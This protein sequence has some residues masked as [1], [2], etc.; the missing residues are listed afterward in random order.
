MRGLFARLRWICPLAILLCGFVGSYK[1]WQKSVENENAERQIIIDTIAE[2]V[3]Q[4]IKKCFRGAILLA[5]GVSAFYD[6]S[7][8]IEDYEFE[9]FTSSFLNNDLISF[10]QWTPKIDFKNK[11]KFEYQT[12]RSLNQP[13]SIYDLD[14]RLNRID[15]KD[16]DV[17]FP[18]SYMQPATGNH[19]LYGYDVFSDPNIH[20]AF[21]SASESG[22]AML[23]NVINYG[24]NSKGEIVLLIIKP[25]YE[26]EYAKSDSHRSISEVL[27][28]VGVAVDMKKLI[29][30]FS[31]LPSKYGQIL[32]I[33]DIT[34]SKNPRGIYSK[35]IV[36][37]SAEN[38][39]EKFPYVE[40]IKIL[41]K[42]WSV[43]GYYSDETKGQKVF[44][45]SVLLVGIVFTALIA[46]LVYF[47]IGVWLRSQQIIALNSKLNSFNKELEM[48][49]KIRTKDLQ[50]ANLDLQEFIACSS[51]DMQ[52][53][54]GNIIIFSQL[55]MND[56]YDVLNED[57]KKIINIINNTAIRLKSHILDLLEYSKISSDNTPFMRVNIKDVLH[58][59]IGSLSKPESEF[60]MN[61]DI[62][63]DM[64][65]LY[66]NEN[67][68]RQLFTCLIDNSIKFRKKDSDLSISV[69][70]ETQVSNIAIKVSDNGI[71]F[72]EK[73]VDRVFNPFQR[74]H[75]HGEYNGSGIGLAIV[76]KIA[77]RHSGRIEVS[78]RIGE[79]SV[80]TLIVPRSLPNE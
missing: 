44:S 48:M 67:Q 28:F 52:A 9:T 77:E 54:H 41:N 30:E 65:I 78:S 37:S 13:L 32:D 4:D 33:E 39:N 31:S 74:L 46:G 62:Q 40:K 51:N 36:E 80:F 66:G 6:S 24:R 20:A 45:T 47:M 50:I 22:K 29:S 38:S 34:N 69:T 11:N 76:K 72:D 1:L 15:A 73:F 8:S 53:L 64:P 49:V 10:I 79:G 63:N 5:K 3:G 70:A 68:L 59:I 27:G 61:C 60:K 57:G 17:Y 16:R 7:V 12:S 2:N 18:I 58:E 23:V 56:Y 25:V 21:L 75:T 71:G 19:L 26:K 55:L 42:T 14:D 35:S 43:V